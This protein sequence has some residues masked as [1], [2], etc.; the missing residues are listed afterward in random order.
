ML[1]G[2]IHDIIKTAP[3]GA[4]IVLEW[5]REAKT[6]KGSPSISKAVR[7]VGRVGVAYDNLK[8]VREKRANGE[9]PEENQ[10]LAEWAEWAEY[11]FLIRHKTKG[12]VY[13][14]MYKGTSEKVKP[15]V[16]FFMD[17]HQVERADIEAHLLASEKQSHDDSDTFMVKVD[18]LKRVY[19]ENDDFATTF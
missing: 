19:N 13:L 14:R 1:L 2:Q 11:P 3:K 6:R 7:M 17:G 5:V 12:T 18:D 9:L 8:S 10:G 16:A 15:K 4:N